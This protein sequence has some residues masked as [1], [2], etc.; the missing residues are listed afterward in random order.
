MS[1]PYHQAL[2]LVLGHL[3]IKLSAFITLTYGR[4]E[5]THIVMHRNLMS[6]F[7]NENHSNLIIHNDYTILIAFK[8]DTLY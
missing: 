4:T 3:N 1:P 6:I 7:A 5:R 2:V 8:I